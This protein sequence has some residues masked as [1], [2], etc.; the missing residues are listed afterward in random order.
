MHVYLIADLKTQSIQFNA[1][2][3]TITQTRYNPNVLLEN[4]NTAAD[5]YKRIPLGDKKEPATDTHNLADEISN[6]LC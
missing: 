6:A 3:L 5:P 2:L 1:A 4:R